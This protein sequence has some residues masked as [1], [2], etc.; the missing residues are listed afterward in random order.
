MLINTISRPHIATAFILKRSI[1][2]C[3][4]CCFCTLSW[5]VLPRCVCS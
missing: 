1:D 5:R 3:L 2:I 4:P